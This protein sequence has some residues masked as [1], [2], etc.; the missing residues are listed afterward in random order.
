MREWESGSV[1]EGETAPAVHEAL[2]GKSMVV[3]AG[4]QAENIEKLQKAGLEH[5]ISRDSNVLQTLIK[6][7][8]ALLQPFDSKEP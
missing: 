2:S 4:Y 8:Q 3:I 1:G 7:N 6:F 5:F